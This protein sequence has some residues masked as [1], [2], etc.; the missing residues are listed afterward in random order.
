MN[1]LHCILGRCVFTPYPIYFYPLKFPSTSLL[2]AYFCYS[3]IKCNPG[4]ICISQG[5]IAA[6]TNT[7]Q[8][9]NT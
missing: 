5:S 2:S 4:N 1:A 7:A 9:S 6:E 3:T 8:C